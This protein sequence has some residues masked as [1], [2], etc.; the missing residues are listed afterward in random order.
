MLVRWLCLLFSSASWAIEVKS[1][2][3]SAPDTW[4]GLTPWVWLGLSVL[5]VI[6]VGTL[7]WLYVTLKR[8]GKEQERMALIWRHIPDSVCEVDENGIIKDLNHPLAKDL[9]VSDFIGTSSFDYLDDKGKTLFRQHL[10]QVIDTGRPYE[11][12]LEVQLHGHISYCYN[13]MMPLLYRDDV[14]VLVMTTDISRYKD[15]QR[16]LEQDKLQSERILHS[17]AQFLMNV[18]Q[19]MSEPIRILQDTFSE[20]RAKAS[21]SLTQPIRTMK[22]SLE[23]LS[24]I[25]A[26]MSVLAQS[27]KGDIS[28]ESVNTSLWYIIDDLEAL[29]LPQAKQKGINLSI[30]HQVLPHYIQT[31]AFRLR[32]VLYNLMS[33]HLS[34]C[35]QGRLGLEIRQ[36]EVAN[37][38]VIYFKFTNA[39]APEAVTD[40]VKRFNDGFEQSSLAGLDP[41]GVSAIKVCHSLAGHLQGILGAKAAESGVIEQWFVLPLNWIHQQEKLSLFKQQPVCLAINDTVANEW[42]KV[43]F[44]SLQVN[45]QVLEES[46]VLPET[47]SLLVSDHLQPQDCPWIWWLGPEQELST[48]QGVQLFAPYRRESLFYRLTDYQASYQREDL[49]EHIARILLVEDN[50]NNQLVIKRTLEKLGYD[51]VLA[52]NGQEGVDQYVSESVDCII[53]DI[54]MPVMD[55]IEA[56][57]I[58]RGMGKPYIPI[59]ALTAN[60]QIEVEKACYEAGMDSFLTK[61]ISRQ[62]IKSTLEQYLGVQAEKTPSHL[63]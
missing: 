44:Q 29:Y 5:L 33:C 26:D 40:W 45:V 13:R 43:F 51:V 55:G 47:M 21:K 48:S 59:I 6:S 53:M 57:R 11:Y 25:V 22:A 24:Q 62:S 54:A 52:N 46:S 63:A 10:N 19:E 31:D 37:E 58:I 30:F 1:V 12:E 61:P 60:S 27:K 2:S 17:K 23:H 39:I 35:Q 16:I 8:L 28:L 20:L 34:I 36:S 49:G 38:P 3:V 9:K 4:L 50:L 42:F 14:R 18:S 41:F 15:A 56:T 32:Q 7:T